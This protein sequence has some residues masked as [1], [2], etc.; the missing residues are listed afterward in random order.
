MAGEVIVDA[1]PYYDKG[2]EEPGVRD[3][4]SWFIFSFFELQIMILFPS[5]KI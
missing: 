2:Y 1:L 3:A 5:L 4:V